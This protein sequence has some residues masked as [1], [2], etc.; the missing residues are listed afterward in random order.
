MAT[1]GADP[2]EVRTGDGSADPGPLPASVEAE[3]PPPGAGGEDAEPL[4]QRYIEMAHAF[5]PRPSDAVLRA[6]DVVISATLLAAAAP[7]IGAAALLIWATSGRPVLYRGDRVG[8]MGIV[9]EMYKFRTLAADAETRLSPY[10]GEELT[11]RTEAEVTSL[12]RILRVMHLDEI[13]QLF[14]VLRGDMSIV[15]P[16]PI[17]PPFF[18]LLCQRVPQYWQRLVVRPGITGFA[19]TRVTRET[20]WEDKLAHD[21]EYIADRSPAL[22]LQMVI[23]TVRRVLFRT[24]V[25]MQRRARGTSGRPPGE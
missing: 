3:L 17:R 9:F 16:R 23:A 25:G 8:R 19:Q 12:G 4:S 18:E 14:N 11:Q 20:T 24:R 10:L 2:A 15:G 1:P 13:P 7:V 6:L 22:Y 21:L 5:E